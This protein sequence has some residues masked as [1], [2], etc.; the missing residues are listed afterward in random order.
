MEWDLLMYQV[1]IYLFEKVRR[2]GERGSERGSE[3]GRERDLRSSHIHTVTYKH[4]FAIT[5]PTL[6]AFNLTSALTLKPRPLTFLFI[7]WSTSQ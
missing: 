7:G 1:L 4:I 2:E 6:Y 3:R 5:F